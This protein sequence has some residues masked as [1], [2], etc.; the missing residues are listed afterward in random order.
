M[1]LEYFVFFLKYFRNNR[2]SKQKYLKHGYFLKMVDIDNN[3]LIGLLMISWGGL[4][5]SQEHIWKKGESKG[6]GCNFG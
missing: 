3:K 5:L 2:F 6:N 1:L 4:L